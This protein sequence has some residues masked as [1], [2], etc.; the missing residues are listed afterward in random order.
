[1]PGSTDVFGIPFPCL[2]DAINSDQFASYAMGV[3]GALNTVWAD[4]NSALK[5]PAVSVF[6][7]GTQNVATGVTT[8]LAYNQVNYDRGG[9][10]TLATPTILTI[11]SN[12]SYFLAS[13]SSVNLTGNVTSVRWAFLRN[14][15]EVAYWESQSTGA[16][17][18]APSETVNVLLPA[19]VAGDQITMNVLYTGTQPTL[20][21][22]GRVN[23]TRLAIP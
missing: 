19:L 21:F 9:F 16:L 22:F 7:S 8:A 11:P 14:G 6:Q 13:T 20:A 2:G 3:E 23:V 18:P 1:M 5:P 4:A 15:A 17:T 10:F 12:G